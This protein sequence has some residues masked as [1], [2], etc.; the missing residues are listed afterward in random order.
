MKHKFW[1]ESS[2]TKALNRRRYIYIYIYMWKMQTQAERQALTQRL[3]T[4][5]KHYT[6]HECK[7]KNIVR[8][9]VRHFPQI[10]SNITPDRQ[11][12]VLATGKHISI[13]TPDGSPACEREVEN[14]MRCDED[15]IENVKE[16]VKK[17]GHVD[18]VAGVP[19]IRNNK[20][21]GHRGYR[22]SYTYTPLYVSGLYTLLHC[23]HA[24]RVR[25]MC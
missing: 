21:K 3:F 20:S 15:T 17:E 18:F 12:W 22:N 14:S 16:S 4:W 23:I 24:N 10:S 9:C 1:D 5:S 11:D 2:D 13:F 7:T 19:V 8:L 25:L 6:K